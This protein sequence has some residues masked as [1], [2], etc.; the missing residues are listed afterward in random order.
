DPKREAGFVSFAQLDPLEGHNFH[1]TEP[2]AW[3][4]LT[5]GRSVYVRADTGRIYKPIEN[6]PPESGT[7]TGN[8]EIK[9]FAAKEGGKKVDLSG[10]K[11]V[12]TVKTNSLSFESSVGE[13]STTE[14]VVVLFEGGRFEGTDVSLVVNQPEEKLMRGEVRKG[15]FIR[16]SADSR[17]KKQ[18]AKG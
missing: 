13:V 7:V 10:D 18:P 11:P 15:G 14:L 4:Y 12:M 1:V 17:P 5:D 8:V 6:Q 2:E 16:F 9:M 3:F